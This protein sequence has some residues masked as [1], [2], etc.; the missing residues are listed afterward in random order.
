MQQKR[1]ANLT[2]AHW[3]TLA[4]RHNRKE[5]PIS[6]QHTALGQCSLGSA[7]P[8][9]WPH[10]IWGQSENSGRQS[11]HPPEPRWQSVPACSEHWR[12][13]E[14][15]GT[16]WLGWSAPLK[17]RCKEL[18][19]YLFQS[20]TLLL[21]KPASFI[22]LQSGVPDKTLGNNPWLRSDKLRFSVCTLFQAV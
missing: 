17:V 16:F 1:T 11:C 9:S 14:H 10:T 8:S 13:S 21:P 20:F 7:A 19:I 18:F 22:R 6:P 5:Q 4:I 12:S 3:V 2:S 15:V